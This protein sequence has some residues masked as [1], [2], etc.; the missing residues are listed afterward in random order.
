[1]RGYLSCVLGS[2]YGDEVPFE[3]T[4][5]L[6]GQLHELGCDEISLGDTIGIGTPLNVTKLIMSVAKN[7]SIAK[8]A[9]HFHDTYGQALANI[10]A[11]LSLGVTIV[12]SS[13]SGIGGCPYA[14]GAT[15]NVATEDV[16]YMLQGMHIK[17]NV[18]LEKLIQVGRFI[19]NHLKRPSQSKVNLAYEKKSTAPQ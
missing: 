8:I 15:G 18:N 19:S 5:A 10:Y 12:D 6:A 11:A 16:L 14:A 9:V 13:V 1:M 17:T 2:P 3:K 7:V 4:A